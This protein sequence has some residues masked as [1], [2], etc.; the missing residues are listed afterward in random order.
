MNSLWSPSDS[1][2]ESDTVQ[3]DTP[4]PG[5]DP[6]FSQCVH[7]IKWKLYQA[8]VLGPELNTPEAQQ[9]ELLQTYVNQLERLYRMFEK[10]LRGSISDADTRPFPSSLRH[11]ILSCAMGLK[12]RIKPSASAHAADL[13]PYQD[14][15]K[16]ILRMYPFVHRTVG[17]DDVEAEAL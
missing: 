5:V 6:H 8:I 9:N 1:D 2:S 12:E 14:Q 7:S 13:I 16:Q 11:E 17:G 3:L 15:L 4:P 10:A